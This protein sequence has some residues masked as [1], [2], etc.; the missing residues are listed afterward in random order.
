M[1]LPQPR[2]GALPRLMQ[3]TDRIDCGGQWS[4]GDG[5][6]GRSGSDLAVGGHF[7]AQVFGRH[8]RGTT[9]RTRGAVEEIREAVWRVVR[10][11]ALGLRRSDLSR[12]SPGKV[13]HCGR[14]DD[15]DIGYLHARRT[16]RFYGAVEQLERTGPIGFSGASVRSRCSRRWAAGGLAEAAHRDARGCGLRCAGTREES[17]RPCFAWRLVHAGQPVDWSAFFGPVGGH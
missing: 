1:A 9:R 11:S 16:V 10:V 14:A 17:E 2:S 6:I 3:Y 13:S 5:G 12:M 7:E 8:D 4:A 15:S